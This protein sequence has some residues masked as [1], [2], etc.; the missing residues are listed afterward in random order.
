MGDLV[1]VFALEDQAL[2]SSI[3][4]VWDSYHGARD[5]GA[6][7]FYSAVRVASTVDRLGLAFAAGYSAALEHLI[8]DVTLP[9]A[10]CVTEADGNHPRAIKASLK[11]SNAGPGYTLDGAKTFV[12]FGNI[13]KTLIVAARNRYLTQALFREF[14]SCAGRL[15]GDGARHLDAFPAS[16]RRRESSLGLNWRRRNCVLRDPAAGGAGARPRSSVQS[17][18]AVSPQRV[19]GRRNHPNRCRHRPSRRAASDH[20]TMCR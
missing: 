9:C 5:S 2:Q 19:L 4:A 8:P 1:S 18:V 14:H 16:A 10:L 12:T 20:T 11:A 15:R 13:A 7:P 6:D 3:D 17:F